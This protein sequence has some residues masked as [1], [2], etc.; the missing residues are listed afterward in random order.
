VTITCP[1]T[2]AIDLT[3]H[4][5][6]IVRAAEEPDTRPEDTSAGAPG[7]APPCHDAKEVSARGD[8]DI[9]TSIAAVIEL[10]AQVMDRVT[11]LQR[12]LAPRTCSSSRTRRIS[13]ASSPSCTGAN[14]ARDRTRR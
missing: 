14:K 9:P 10:L 11:Q 3:V 1:S 13:H 2:C 4:L 12:Q 6:Q 8:A 7:R 5:E